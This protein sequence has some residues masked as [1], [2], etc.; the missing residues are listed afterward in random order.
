MVFLQQ[1]T[2][3]HAGIDNPKRPIMTAFFFK[4]PNKPTKKKWAVFFI[5]TLVLLPL[6]MPA[7]ASVLDPV[8]KLLAPLYQKLAKPTPP[9]EQT[10]TSETPSSTDTE[11]PQNP[12]TQDTNISNTATQNPF[13]A[14]ADTPTP[15]LFAVLQAEF[16]I[17]RGDNETALALYKNQA[18]KDNA[19]AVFERALQLS[20]EL[21]SPIT[22]LEFAQVWQQQNQDH[23]PAWFYVTHLALKAENYPL[24][25]DNLK[26]ILDY[27]AK[28]DLSQIFTGILPSGHKARQQL[29]T[30]LQGLDE[31]E[32]PSLSFLKAGLL[33]QLNEP[34][35]GILHL[36]NAIKA[37]PNNL[38]YHILKADIL[39]FQGEPK[40]LTTFLTQATRQT[41]GDTQKQLYLYHV[42]HLID[43]GDLTGAWQILNRI[44]RTYQDDTA[45]T[46]LASLVALDTER[47]ADANR[48]LTQLT[49]TAIA[50]EAYYYLGL[51][52]ER[53]LELE[54]ADEY[55]AKVDDSQ[56]VLPATQ[57]RVAYWLAQGNTDKAMEILTQLRTRF[58]LYASESYTMQADILQK[59]GKK[60]DAIALLTTAYQEYPDDM[61][62]LYASTRL[63]DNTRHFAQKQA[64]LTALLQFDPLNPAYRLDMADLT[65]SQTPTDSPSLQVAKEVSELGFDNPDYDSERHLK[66][67]L[68][69]ANHALHEKNYAQVVEY[70]QTPYDMTPS[71]AVGITLLRGYQGLGDTAMV[72]QLLTDLTLRFGNTTAQSDT[73]PPDGE[74]LIQ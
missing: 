29:F 25:A 13:V 56:F 41:K 68:L 55:F 22:S 74:P 50:G 66:A 12:N 47:Y 31:D 2:F 67:L 17:N 44:T 59:L 34:K 51:S 70:L 64:N 10:D 53:T 73:P 54:Q 14:P 16:A 27:D 23:I 60:D 32:N 46:L 9:S 15:D 52:H 72:G 38:A 7:S 33:A 37:E 19:T 45:I 6:A 8:V 36:N 28:A 69:L 30:A 61:S 4:T 42:R 21:E 11:T 35:A 20:M 57:K 26:M 3:L 48:L 1:F 18:L 65:L 58:A 62:L 24:V 71:L 5:L 49:D 63:M 40:A 39:K 43:T